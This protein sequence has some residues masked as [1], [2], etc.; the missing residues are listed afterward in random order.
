MSRPTTPFLLSAA[1][2]ATLQDFTRPVRAVRCIQAL[3][4]LATDIG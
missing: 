3:L 4:P 2:Q 1:D